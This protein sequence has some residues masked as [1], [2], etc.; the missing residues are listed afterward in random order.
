VSGG[1]GWTAEGGV[2]SGEDR[3]GNWDAPPR[4]DVE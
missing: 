1:F 2:V 3:F 4:P